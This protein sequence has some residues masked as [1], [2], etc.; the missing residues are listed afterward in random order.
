MKGLTPEDVLGASRA[1]AN[2]LVVGMGALKGKNCKIYDIIANP[3]GSNDVIFE[4]EDDNGNVQQS[5]MIVP[6]G[7][8]G[9]S[10]NNADI[11]E[12]GHLILYKES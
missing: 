9:K 6:A 2:S 10:V 3:D 8:A 1:Y 11:D 12:N 5:H 7:P 4:W